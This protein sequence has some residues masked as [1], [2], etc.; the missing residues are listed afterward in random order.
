MRKLPN[1]ENLYS[2]SEASEMIGKSRGYISRRSTD[3]INRD[4]EKR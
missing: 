4:M 1:D 2:L 3:S